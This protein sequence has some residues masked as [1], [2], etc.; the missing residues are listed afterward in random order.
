MNFFRRPFKRK[1][2]TWT[3]NRV[4]NVWEHNGWGNSISWNDWDKRKLGGHLTPKPRVD[5]EIRDKL[6]SGKIGRFRVRNVD[7][8]A[9]VHDMFWC[10]VSDVGY[11]EDDAQKV[12]KT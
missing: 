1:E 5:D 9:S 4:I 6:E 11:L 10:N 12:F 7:Y 8:V 2:E 3:P